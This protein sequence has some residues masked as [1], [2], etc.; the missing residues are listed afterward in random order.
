MGVLITNP[1]VDI[2]GDVAG[3]G[4]STDNAVARFDG[5]TGKLVQNSKATISDNGVLTLSPTGTS[6]DTTFLTFGNETDT[7]PVIAF[8]A[9]GNSVLSIKSNNNNTVL[10]S[11][12]FNGSFMAANGIVADTGST[13]VVSPGSDQTI[14]FAQRTTAAANPPV[15]KNKLY[16]KSDG[17]LYSLNSSGVETQV[18]ASSGANTTL[19]NLGT[20]AINADLLPD[21]DGAWALGSASK[22]WSPV[23]TYSVISNSVLQVASNTGDIQ[24]IGNGATTRP[25]VKF[26]TADLSNYVALKSP[27]TIASNVTLTLP[28][29]AGTNGQVLTT[30]GS[31][32][33]SF[34]TRAT[35]SLSNLASTAV[36]ASII[37]ASALAVDL[38]ASGKEWANLYVNNIYASGNCGSK[39]IDVENAVLADTASVNALNWTQRLLLSTSGTSMLDWGANSDTVELKINHLKVPTTVTTGGTTGAQTIN[40]MSGTVNFA[41][42]A[43]SLTVTCSKVSSTSLVFAVV[44]TNDTTAAIKNVVPS[45]GS[46]IITLTA[47]ATAETSVGFFI[48]NG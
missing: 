42:A 39:M 3:P 7:N 24:F 21:S 43:S 38:G 34:Q 18:D 4:T 31:S 37:P 25:T 19:S 12:L 17:H 48:V 36:N 14:Q 26:F 30:D 46:F 44:R 23:W 11:F 8:D 6:G 35:E 15:N 28:N 20:T 40:K 10:A 1:P 16:F 22:Q 33:L 32:V 45:N 2:S 9:S 13:V 41:A 47:A 29:A 5:T 27:A